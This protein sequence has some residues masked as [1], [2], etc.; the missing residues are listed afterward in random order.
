VV[1]NLKG[2][3]SGNGR[4]RIWCDDVALAEARL[5]ARTRPLRSER[6]VLTDHGR[7]AA[8]ASRNALTVAARVGRTIR[9]QLIEAPSIQ[10]TVLVERIAI[11]RS[12]VITGE[13]VDASANAI[14]LEYD[15]SRTFPSFFWEPARQL[16]RQDAA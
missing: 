2:L 3:S 4:T 8:A 1:R 11:R 13:A 5:A 15:L 6:G 10:V 16:E 9:L 7:W 12:T 14:A